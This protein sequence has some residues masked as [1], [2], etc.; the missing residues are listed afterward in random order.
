MSPA[1]ITSTLPIAIVG[2][3][4]GG[5]ALAIGLRKHGIDFRIYEAASE[6]SEIGAGVAFGPNSTRALGLI[7]P[8]LLE[9]YK[10][11]ATY[12]ENP[13][14]EHTFLSVRWGMNERREGGSKAG[15][16]IWHMKDK[17]DPQSAK[18]LGVKTR[19]CIHR[20][21]LLDT[22]VGL[23]PEGVTHFRKSFESLIELADGTIELRFADGTTA[24]V[25]AV[26]GCDGIKSRMREI[27]CA[28]SGVNAS[29][30]YVGECAFRAMVPRAAAIEALG[31]E[32]AGN[33]QIFCG[34]GAYIVTYPVERGEFVNMVAIPHDEGESWAWQSSE[35]TVPTT[36]D[37]FLQHFQGWDLPH[38]ELIRQ[39]CT[40]Q[41][42]ALFNVKHSAPYYQG[43]IC[44]M[45]DSAH[46]TTPHL[47]AGAGMAMED[48]Y[49]LS[50][51][52][53][54]AHG[55]TDIGNAFKAYDAV[56]RPR[57]QQLIE[58]SRLAGL[59]TDFLLPGVDDSADA[60]QEKY[61]AWYKWLWHEDLVAQLDSAKRLV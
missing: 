56:R 18:K 16:L 26:V 24:H 27:V 46:A 14:H 49:V 38:I 22:L 57:T 43:R 15:D 17:W 31:P 13:D 19:S 29:P 20:A 47:G 8:A 23:L 6:F 12:N 28:S 55:S 39:Y 51:L 54:H 30:S 10:Q 25:G 52:I 33:G 48:A 40:P 53:A 34:Y 21:K 37:E 45:G 35:W 5:L 11:H 32:L 2:G 7:H 58:N 36:A 1:T 3:G 60:L 44:L 4:L 61:E 42:W 50:N 41:R 59:A 9:G